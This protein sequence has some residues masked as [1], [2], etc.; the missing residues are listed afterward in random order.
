MSLVAQRLQGLL[1]RNTLDPVVKAELASSRLL[2]P[3]TDITASTVVP[4][5]YPTLFSGIHLREG[6]VALKRVHIGRKTIKVMTRAL[7]ALAF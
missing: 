6:Q 7:S 1:G 5:P 3:V 2:V 4:S